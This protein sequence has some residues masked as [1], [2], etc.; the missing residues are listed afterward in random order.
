MGKSDLWTKRVFW[1]A[2][3]Y[4]VVALIPNYFMETRFGMD[5]PPAITH[6]EFYYGFTGV[7]LAWQVAFFIIAKNPVRYRAMMI[8]SMLEKV[9]FGAAVGVLWMQSR[10]PVLFVGAGA[11]DLALAGLFLAAFLKTPS[12]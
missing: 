8:P 5:H 3:A 6:P 11:V 7:G 12:E 4:G 1:W 10:V 2:G 9:A